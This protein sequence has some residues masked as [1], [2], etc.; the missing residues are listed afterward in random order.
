MMC[1]R[2]NFS[3]V[4]ISDTRTLSRSDSEFSN[5]KAT[6]PQW[7]AAKL[8]YPKTFKM[9]KNRYSSIFL[10]PEP[11]HADFS[12][13]KQR[14]LSWLDQLLFIKNDLNS[15]YKKTFFDGE[16][17]IQIKLEL[18]NV[19]RVINSLIILFLLSKTSYELVAAISSEFE[20]S[21]KCR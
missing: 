1:D 16:I 15:S 11:S 4:E 21:L 8:P 19:V 12:L 14:L 13:I 18:I 10:S 9:L 17:I 3:E 7:I 5:V 20:F 6:S 2:G